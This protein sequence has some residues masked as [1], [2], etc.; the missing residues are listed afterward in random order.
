[1]GFRQ[2]LALGPLAIY[3]LVLGI[4]NLS[5]RPIVVSGGRDRLALGI[6]VCGMIAVGPVELFLPMDVAIF[7]GGYVWLLLGALYGLTI[8][9]LAVVRRPRLSI[10]NI[11]ETEL[12]QVLGELVVTLDPGSQWTGEIL[13]LPRLGV[14]LMIDSVRSLRNVSLIPVGERQSYEGWAQLEAA[15]VTELAS[16][17]VPP[18]PRGLTL[19]LIGSILLGAITWSLVRDPLR[20]SQEVS[21]MLFR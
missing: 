11:S 5:R 14:Q 12:R 19:A 18:N 9:L 17:Q 15:L 13:I 20:I 7:F 2:C 10:Y 8:L 3:F 6:A 16:V 21:E 4:I 1:M